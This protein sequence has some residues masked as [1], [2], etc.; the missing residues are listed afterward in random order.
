MKDLALLKR[1]DELADKG[2]QLAQL[3]NVEKYELQDIFES[4]RFQIQTIKEDNSLD[5]LWRP[6]K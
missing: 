6:K 1:I 3:K 2:F 4:I 5:F